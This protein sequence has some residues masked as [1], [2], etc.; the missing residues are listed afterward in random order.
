MA[1]Y[2]FILEIDLDATNEIERQ[3]FDEVNGEGACMQD[4]VTSVEEYIADMLPI[5]IDIKITKA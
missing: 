1:K 5:G 2:K 3:E 4:F